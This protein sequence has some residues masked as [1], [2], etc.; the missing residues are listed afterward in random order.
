GESVYAFPN[1]P[2]YYFLLD[3]PNPTRYEW[4]YQAITRTMRL[5]AVSDLQKTMPAYIIFSTD[6]R[7]RLDHI[8][9]SVAVPEILK[10][11]RDH[12]KRWVVIGREEILI[13]KESSLP[14][15]KPQTID[16]GT[17]ETESTEETVEE[18]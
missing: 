2:L 7:Q 6:P 15:E 12:Y 3:S 18:P 17:P 9:P 10:F 5:E 13:P 4:S 16:T 11:I 14:E 1:L 8:P